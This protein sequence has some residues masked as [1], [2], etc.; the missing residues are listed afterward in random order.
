MPRATDT[1]RKVTTGVEKGLSAVTV[2]GDKSGQEAEDDVRAR[3]NEGV[4]ADKK[5][6]KDADVI[7]EYQE[8]PMLPGQGPPII[9]CWNEVISNA[10]MGWSLTKDFGEI[11]LPSET[12]IQ[13]CSDQESNLNVEEVEMIKGSC[14]L[15]NFP[16]LSRED[17]DDDVQE[18]RA[19]DNKDTKMPEQVR[20]STKFHEEVMP[21]STE[22]GDADK[23]VGPQKGNAATLISPEEG[24]ADTQ[25]SPE[26]GNT[27]SQVG[28]EMNNA[29][30]RVGHHDGNAAPQVGP[31][32]G[33]SA[34]L[35]DQ[36]EGN[37]AELTGPEE[38]KDAPQVGLEEGNAADLVGPPEG[39]AGEPFDPEEGKSTGQVDPK[40]DNAD[41]LTK[42]KGID[43][44]ERVI[45]SKE[46]AETVWNQ[47]CYT[48]MMPEMNSRAVI[49]LC[50]L[51]T[52]CA[53]EYRSH[54]SYESV[55]RRSLTKEPA[56]QGSPE[57]DRFDGK[58]AHTESATE[59]AQCWPE[60]ADIDC[61]VNKVPAGQTTDDNKAG[62]NPEWK[63]EIELCGLTSDSGTEMDYHTSQGASGSEER[64]VQEMSDSVTNRQKEKKKKS[65]K[66]QKKNKKIKLKEARLAENI[67]IKIQKIFQSVAGRTRGHGVINDEEEKEC[68]DAYR[69]LEPWMKEAF[70]E[71]GYVRLKHELICCRLGVMTPAEMDPAYEETLG[72][73]NRDLWNRMQEAHKKGRCDQMTLL[74]MSCTSIEQ[75]RQFEYF[76]MKLGV[77]SR[78]ELERANVVLLEDD[79]WFLAQESGGVSGDMDSLAKMALYFNCNERRGWIPPGGESS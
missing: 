38:G 66:L 69:D 61:E 16:E 57:Q 40:E 5:K 8:W 27:G 30:R 76:R 10:M 44:V 22:K 28:S 9:Y 52:E 74:S 1:K 29:G 13:K 36:T 19:K 77:F 15:V 73:R 50:D 31:K 7:Q 43:A 65:K 39:N 42:S 35:V 23:R 68:R 60:R 20:S 3:E 54:E 70:N 33:N 71:K 53:D 26:E 47:S 4:H 24:N 59:E 6:M 62:V 14:R 48:E 34:E 49:E 11:E 18:T 41:R 58:L 32:E 64:D 78:E 21:E 79:L 55:N 2:D 25:V 51:R 67:Q 72:Q 45:P 12:E 46:N 37:A 75:S 56:E 17:Y 63:A